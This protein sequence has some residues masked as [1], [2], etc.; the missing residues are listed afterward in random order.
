[1]QG[2]SLKRLK[3][4]KARDKVVRECW[5]GS[6]KMQED[7]I[8]DFCQ[9][10][11]NFSVFFYIVFLCYFSITGHS[12]CQRFMSILANGTQ[13]PCFL[14]LSH[15][16]TLFSKSE[17]GLTLVILIRNP[18]ELRKKHARTLVENVCRV[19]SAIEE[20]PLS[21]CGCYPPD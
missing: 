13:W 18:W 4:M 15:C 16:F 9:W 2:N 12:T 8:S 21:F 19:R 1:M 10:L 5:C 20:I 3:L 7:L 11:H 6:F 14:Y 17:Q